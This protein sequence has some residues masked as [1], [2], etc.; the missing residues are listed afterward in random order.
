ML[1][2]A[3]KEEECCLCGRVIPE[4]HK[5]WKKSKFRGKQHLNCCDYEPRN[6]ARE[7]IEEVKDGTGETT[8]QL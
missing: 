6:P 7:I 1:Y 2:V 3:G 5:Y 4:G 8:W